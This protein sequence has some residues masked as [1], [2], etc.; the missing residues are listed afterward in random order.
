[1]ALDEYELEEIKREIVESRSLSIKTNNLV[2]ALASDVK[3]IA[4]RH[5]MQE[6]RLIV[7][8]ATAYVVTI[9]VVLGFVKLAWDLRL[10]AVR[11]ETH[12]AEERATSL[13]KQ[14]KGLQA[15]EEGVAK[16][17]RQASD[18]YQLVAQNKRRE[19]IEGFP[20][21]AKADLTPTERATFEAAVDRAKDELSLIAYQTGVDH[22]RM[23]RWHEAQ[24]SLRESLQYK[25]DA[26]HSPQANY[27]LARA[28]IA[29]GAEHIAP[30]IALNKSDLVEPFERAWA[31]LVP[32][33]HMGYGVLPLS[34]R[35]SGE[36]DRE[37]LLKHL[38]GKTTLVLGP[39]GAGKS[40]LINLLAP[41]ARAEVG[42]RN[43]QERAEADARRARGLA[44]AAGQAK[45][46]MPAHRVGRLQSSLGHRAHEVEPAAGR[47]HLLAEHTIGRTLRQ[48]D[49]AVDARSNRRQ[50]LWCVE[51]VDRRLRHQRPATKRSRL[52]T[53]VGS[54][55]CL[56]ARITASAGAGTGPHGSMASRTARGPR[57][58]TTPPST[59]ATNARSR[60]IPRASATTQQRLTQ[61]SK[62]NN[63][64]NGAR[65]HG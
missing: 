50:R 6:R 21:I 49:P 42:P 15:R 19:I 34:L 46:E 17:R 57:S 48:T 55:S 7:N 37:H 30:F 59:S 3:S 51:R 35:M 4:K 10:D 62:N 5:Q 1:M 39:S 8:T 25:S 38:H 43:L 64:I 14:L 44:R 29:A 33:Q 27:Q 32:Y 61:V 22:I 20:E 11:S 2:N 16:A 63:S 60:S 12:S 45:V 23:Q 53:P 41:G 28:L 36:T 31:R 26:A 13:E 54:N 18:F 52:S 9:L 56:I 40:T 47:V 58:I 24:Q 65:C